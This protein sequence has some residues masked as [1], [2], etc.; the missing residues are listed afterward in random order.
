MARPKV[1]VT[2]RIAEQALDILRKECEVTVGPENPGLPKAEIVRTVGDCDGLLP[3]GHF[4]IDSEIMSAAPRLRVIANFGVGVDHIDISAASARGIWVSNTAGSL[5]EAT[6]ELGW[7]LILA[8]ARRIAEG[9]RFVRAGKWQGFGPFFF[10]GTEL[11][12]KT[13]GIVGGGRIGQAVA[14]RAPPFGMKVVY[15]SRAPRP[16]FDA[17]A[18]RDLDSLLRE[19][20]IVILTLSLAP[21]TR[22]LISDR[23]LG[24]MKKT[25]HLVNIAR[26]PIVDEPALAR[27]LLE[28][29]IAGAGLDVF[30]KEPEI[31][32]DLLRCEN[33]VVIPHIGS[34]TIETRTRMGIIAAENCIAGVQGRVPPLALNAAE[35][36][37]LGVRR[38]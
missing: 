24:L 26:G 13:I 31:H 37:A 23:Q 4:K 8:T 16:E 33:A 21:E 19:S 15:W 17:A 1:F 7:A 20:D 18:Y 25:A 38:M 30:E 12:G 6:A 34:A 36:G 10:L 3:V 5:T 11:V 2:R 35:V 32:P 29:R 27:A 28:G 9:D 22:H 14:K